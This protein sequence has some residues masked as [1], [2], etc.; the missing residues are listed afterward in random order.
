[1]PHI[2]R[3]ILKLLVILLLPARLFGQGADTSYA[4]YPD[5]YYEYQLASMD[6]RSTIGFDFTPRVKHYLEEYIDR[7]RPQVAQMLGLAELYFPLFD[8]IIARHGLPPELRYLA[9]VESALNPRAV[10]RSQ[11]VGLWQFKLNSGIIY[12]LTV[13]SIVDLRMDP[14]AST[15]A[16]CLYLKELHTAF[17][18]WHLAL[19]A[20][21]MGPTALQAVLNRCKS[22]R[23]WEI[24][25]MLPEA[26]QNY[27]PAFIA[28]AYVMQHPQLHGI[29]PKAAPIAHGQTCTIALQRPAQLSELAT[30][31]EAPIEML[32]MLNPQL[33]R[34]VAPAGHRL[35]V[36]RTAR[37]SI[38][39]R[40]AAAPEAALPAPRSSDIGQWALYVALPGDTLMRIAQKHSC[41]V[42]DI[43]R[44][45]PS[46]S[47]TLRVGERIK[48][49]LP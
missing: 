49:R 25:P 38:A 37:A 45:N 14:T 7:R 27:V 29:A 6:G 20:Y 32:E 47:T 22:R 35:R 30:P 31:P 8:S 39:A 34:L 26:A 12:G 11:A 41:S 43:I 17:G 21:N 5:L 36:P 18:D 13:D 28:A 4:A 9:V 16:A 19:T 23:F 44:W 2:Q 48:L 42:A 10:S 3:L 24:C 40:A 1:M 15:E 46:I 33:V